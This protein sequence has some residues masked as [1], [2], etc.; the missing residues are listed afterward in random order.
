M[1]A[2]AEPVF[3]D[4]PCVCR[5]PLHNLSNQ[6][7]HTPWTS[8]HALL[9]FTFRLDYSRESTPRM[10]KCITMSE[11]NIS[12]L[13]P[14]HCVTGLTPH[15]TVTWQIRELNKRV[16]P[17]LSWSLCYYSLIKGPKSNT[18]FE[19]EEQASPPRSTNS[20]YSTPIRLLENLYQTESK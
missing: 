4:G 19:I 12:T 2:D 20:T 5:I 11:W 8:D 14:L 17:M 13:K 7:T 3:S 1:L 10:A 18:M 9:P 15:L 16:N 6:A